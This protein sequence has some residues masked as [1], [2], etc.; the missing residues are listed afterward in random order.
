[1]AFA[2]WLRA[3]RTSLERRS[4]FHQRQKHRP[5]ARSAR[6]NLEVLEDRCLL[7]ISIN[8][9]GGLT[10]SSNPYYIASGPDGNLWFTE[11]FSNQIGEINPAT[12]AV[13]EFGGLTA[14]NVP[15]GITAGPDGNL[16]F[17]EYY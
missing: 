10:P 16:W 14:N 6:P 1:M 8:E 2:P 7:S 12:D 5:R 3:L 17:T 15:A 4:A 9:F 11:V 13:N